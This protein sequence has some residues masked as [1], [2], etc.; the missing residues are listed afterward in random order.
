MVQ[1]GIRSYDFRSPDKFSKDDLRALELVGNHYA[2]LAVPVLT[3]QLRLNASFELREIGQSTYGY[4]LDSLPPHTVTAILTLGPLAGRF[5]AMLDPTIALVAIDLLMGGRGVPIAP[6]ALTDIEL[7]L[8]KRFLSRLAGEFGDAI[9][10]QGEFQVSLE[11][12]EANALFA[13]ILAPTETIASLRFTLRVEHASGDFTLVLPHDLVEPLLP[14]L[15]D[16][17]RPGS[18]TSDLW[19]LGDV[20][21]ELSA[22]LGSVEMT[23]AQFLALEV[24]DILML[25]SRTGR[26]LELRVAGQRTF[27]G[28]VGTVGRELVFEIADRIAKGEWVDG[29]GS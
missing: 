5:L 21:L 22:V 17:A 4:F 13:Q 7:S 20:P 23:L 2:R 18:R 28:H 19:D 11:T 14:R 6:R 8:L 3:A 25:P 27:V 10:E 15:I 29:R 9:A 16:R 24:G 26:P 1:K 12:I